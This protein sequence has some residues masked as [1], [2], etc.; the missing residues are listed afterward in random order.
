MDKTEPGRV[1]RPPALPV[2]GVPRLAP[3]NDGKVFSE[4]RIISGY[5]VSLLYESDNDF[6]LTFI[7]IRFLY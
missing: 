6:S 3:G 5:R 2:S 4:L 7:F 1:R